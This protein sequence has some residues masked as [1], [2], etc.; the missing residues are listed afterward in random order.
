V[1]TNPQSNKHWIID[2]NNKKKYYLILQPNYV[3]FLKVLQIKYSEF[4]NNLR[5][6]L[7]MHTSDWQNYVCTS[8]CEF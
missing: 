8:L 2:D 4:K 3:D 7:T 5:S 1:R 6:S